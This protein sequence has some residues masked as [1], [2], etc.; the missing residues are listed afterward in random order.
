MKITRSYYVQGFSV[1]LSKCGYIK[2]FIPFYVMNKM[3]FLYVK[4]MQLLCSIWVNMKSH[5]NHTQN[6]MEQLA[7]PAQSGVT[8]RNP[9][10]AI[11]EASRKKCKT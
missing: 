5:C 9:E 6:R 10:N 8:P 2:L 11:S 7:L 1:S 4:L 3:Q